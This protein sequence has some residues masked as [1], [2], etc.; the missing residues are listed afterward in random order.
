MKMATRFGVVAW[1]LTLTAGTAL[2]ANPFKDCQDM[3]KMGVPGKAGT[4]LCR[5]GYALA[6]DPVK[7]TPIWVAEYLDKKRSSGKLDRS[8]KFAPDP[9]LP[10][11]RRAELADYKSASKQ[12]DRG[13][14]SP[15][16]DNAW[17]SDAMDESFYL[18]NMTPQVGPSMNRGIWMR[19]ET[20]VRAWAK[21]RGELYVYS[22]PIYAKGI[23]WKTI[24]KNKVGVPISFF[25]IA[26]DP[27]SKEAIAFI[28]ENRKLKTEDMP[29]YIVTIDEVEKKTGLSFL[30]A[31]EVAEKKKIGAMKAADVWD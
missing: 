20:K 15:A 14:M 2:A 31:L 28:M 23:P 29:D 5:M 27:K 25:K 19:L 12:Y 9:D 8:D 18:S 10:A 17:D 6:H 22:G 21:D 24:G 30:S 3:M 1:L 26:Y 11:G 16:K 4:P 7:K 13:H